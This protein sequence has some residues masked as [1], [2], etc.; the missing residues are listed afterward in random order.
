V[1]THDAALMDQVDARR[2]IL[3]DGRLEIHD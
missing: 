1:A 3:N 2:L